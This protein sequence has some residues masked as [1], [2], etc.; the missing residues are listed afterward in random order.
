MKEMFLEI[1][2]FTANPY[3]TDFLYSSTDEEIS[4]YFKRG[5]YYDESLGI[6]YNENG[7]SSFNKLR[8]AV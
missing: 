8:N 5:P 3:D 1:N 7:R 2:R 4:N 6:H